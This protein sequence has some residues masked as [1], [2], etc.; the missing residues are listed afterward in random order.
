[1]YMHVPIVPKSSVVKQLSSDNDRFHSKRIWTIIDHNVSGV[2]I[3]D[4]HVLIKQT[5]SGL[6]KSSQSQIQRFHRISSVSSIWIAHDGLFL[7]ALLST[8]ASHI[9]IVA[10]LNNRAITTV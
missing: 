4:I 3:K 10:F 9:L 2:K 8:L 1:M 7:K 6:I 5:N